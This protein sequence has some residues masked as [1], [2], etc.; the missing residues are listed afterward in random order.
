MNESVLTG[1]EARRLMREGDCRGS[2]AGL[3]QDYVQ[4]NLVVLPEG[5]AAAFNR[6]CTLNPKPCP[7]LGITAPGDPDPGALAPGADLR[8]DVVRYR[9]YR[10]GKLAGEVTD[11]A[12]LWRRDSVAFLLGCSFTFEKALV[13]AG[14]PMR[15]L[16][17][18]CTV[19]MFQTALSCHPAEPFMGPLVV[20]MRPIPANLVETAIAVTSRFPLAHG[21][22]IHAG[23]PVQ[24]GITDLSR[25]DY[26]DP[27]PVLV[28]E[29][30]VFW[31]CGVTPQAAIQSAGIPLVITHAPGCMFITDL[32]EVELDEG[33][34]PS[35]GL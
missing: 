33:C 20:T 2:T 18:G 26:G 16:E 21:A 28:G 12:H 19:P 31:A 4:A 1:A 6:F 9:V 25:P 7:L 35:K 32:R 24:L 13:R 17:L 15:H 22:P 29:V 14:I 34:S 5:Y 3:A 11:I 10:D 27:V 30:P 23:D 8:F